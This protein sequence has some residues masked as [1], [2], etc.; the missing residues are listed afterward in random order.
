MNEDNILGF[1]VPMNDP[2]FMHVSEPF[3]DFPGQD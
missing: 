3:E 1:Y 2:M